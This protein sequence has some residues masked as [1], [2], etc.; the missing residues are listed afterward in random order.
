MTREL[1]MARSTYV[2]QFPGDDNFAVYGANVVLVSGLADYLYWAAYLAPLFGL[3]CL[4]VWLRARRARRLE[5][6]PPWGRYA[7][8]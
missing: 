4:A 3:L 8:E 6:V 2:N 5:R 1:L 7:K